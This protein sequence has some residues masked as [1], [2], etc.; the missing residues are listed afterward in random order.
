M[1]IILS[2]RK[3]FDKAIKYIFCYFLKLNFVRRKLKL[4][5]GYFLNPSKLLFS[6]HF[7][8]AGYLKKKIFLKPVVKRVISLFSYD[9]FTFW[10]ILF[11]DSF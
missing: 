1:I 6:P 7:S 10:S 5:A 4:Q 3:W 8:N 9:F 2:R 11:A